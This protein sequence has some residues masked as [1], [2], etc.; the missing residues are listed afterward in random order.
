LESVRRISRELRPP[1]LDEL[2]FGEAVAWRARTFRESTGIAVD[3]KPGR[4]PRLSSEAATA[5]YRVLQEALTNVARHSG[6]G[7]VMVR[8]ARS[9]ESFTMTIA[10]DGRGISPRALESPDS[11]GVI[12][13]R[14]RVR[15]VG[16]EMDITAPE[17][18]GTIVS[19]RLPIPAGRRRKL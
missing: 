3:V 12:G 5:L 9:R 18:G 4:P 6:A 16:G 8:L 19:V 7:R 17:D 14:E 1:I 10:D 11:F 2:G 13:M 15:S